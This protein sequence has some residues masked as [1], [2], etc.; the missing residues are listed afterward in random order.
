MFTICSFGA[1]VFL[2]RCTVSVGDP[3]VEHKGHREIKVDSPDVSKTASKRCSRRD[4]IIPEGYQQGNKFDRRE[5]SN[6]YRTTI[7]TSKCSLKIVF[8]SY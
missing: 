8:C 2:R 1:S 6:L 7:H 4:R 5:N 3:D